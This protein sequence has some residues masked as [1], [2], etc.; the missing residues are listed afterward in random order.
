M[1]PS[2]VF[3]SP[4]TPRFSGN[5]LA[6]RAAHN[7]RALSEKFTVHLLVI[8]IFRP[9]REIP[10]EEIVRL[11]GGWKQL[12]VHASLTGKVVRH[13]KEFVPGRK[14]KM[15]PEWALWNS[16]TDREIDAWLAGLGCRN[17]WVFRFSLYPWIRTRIGHGA[18]VWLDLDELD[19][20]ARER[21]ATLHAKLGRHEMERRLQREAVAFR[22][23]EEQFLPRFDLVVTASRRETERLQKNL[24]GVNL[25]TWPNIISRPILSGDSKSPRPEWTLLFV[26]AFNYFP[27]RDAIRY[28]AE[29]ILPRL[30][31]RLG[32]RPV[33]LQAAGSKMEEFRAEFADLRNVEWLGTVA[34]LTPVYA[35][36]DIVIVP[37]RAGGGTRLKIMEAFAHR[38]AVVST[39]IGAEGLEVEHDR[40]LLLAD[41]PDEIAAACAE[42]LL[43]AEKRD[44]LAAAGCAFGTVHH[45][46][47]AL[48]AGAAALAAEASRPMRGN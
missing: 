16:T 39:R 29:E 9:G 26:G 47:D 27:N 24:P 43:N 31:S 38:K 22:H 40:E 5:G 48:R 1:N 19:S 14:A 35:R 13:L 12:D 7:L 33:L 6:M 20:S 37:L 28:A 4:V 25:G 18:R 42:L 2:L 36:A 17:L 3:I 30:Q 11:C 21:Q 32:A 34:D 44:R 15:P 41:G 45:G 8:S 46:E 10:P 23:C